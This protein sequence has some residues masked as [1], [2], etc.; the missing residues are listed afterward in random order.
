MFR[1]AAGWL[2]GTLT[3]CIGGALLGSRPSQRV[4]YALPR[5]SVEKGKP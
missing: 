3:A 5:N 4:A 1:K 2:L